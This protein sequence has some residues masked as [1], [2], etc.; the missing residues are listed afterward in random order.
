MPRRSKRQRANVLSV[1]ITDK[2]FVDTRRIILDTIDPFENGLRIDCAVKGRAEN[3][4]I[5][6]RA[7][8][9]RIRAQN[10]LNSFGIVGLSS[11]SSSALMRCSFLP[12]NLSTE[13]FR[14][15]LVTQ[16]GERE[17]SPVNWRVV[18]E[19]SLNSGLSHY[20]LSVPIAEARKIDGQKLYIGPTRF[21]FRQ[22][23]HKNAHLEK[24]VAVSSE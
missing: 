11:N 10:L 8:E 2:S 22:L 4:I 14:K 21:V 9:E 1:S 24:S 5:R 18:K 20:L 19:T 15:A 13:Y 17:L 6:F 23:P 16:N 7:I 12:Q 3:V